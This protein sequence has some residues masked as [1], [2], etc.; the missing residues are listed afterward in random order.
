MG[1][2]DPP[3]REKGRAISKI[4]RNYGYLTEHYLVVLL[5]LSLIVL[6]LAG[7]GNAAIVGAMGAAL[8]L[9]GCM[10]GAVKVDLYILLPLLIFDVFS[11]AS[12][13]HAYGTFA[14]GFAPTQTVFTVLYLLIACLDDGERLSLR[15]MCVLWVGSVAALGIVQFALRAQAAYVGRL[16]GLLGN[17]NA[18]GIFLVVGW[19]AMRAWKNEG[20][21]RLELLEPIIL[22]ALAMTLSLGSFLSMA[23]GM[24]ASFL[25]DC[26]QIGLRQ[27]IC[28][29]RQTLAR[30]TVCVGIGM[31]LYIAGRKSGIP[32]LC[33]PLTL[34]LLMLALDWKSFSSF[35]QNRSR[36]A[37]TLSGSGIAVAGAAVLLRPS[38]AATFVERLEMMKSGLRYIL[39]NPFLGVGPYR[40]RVL[41]YND[42]G[43]YFNTWHIHNLFLHVGVELGL[44]A[45][46]ALIAVTIRHFCKRGEPAAKCGSAAFLLHCM[47]DTGFF[48]E[49]V[50]ALALLTVSRPREG[51]RRLGPALSRALF[52][53]LGAVFLYN[54]LR[55]WI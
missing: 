16:G 48:Y 19:F 54:L 20:R 47:M 55:L 9:A 32:W 10:Q 12:S 45:M 35:L 41:D 6:T 2:E 43:I 37:M 8:C 40:W 25:M 15:R 28:R 7:V 33:V 44:V 30:I 46:G 53:L 38:A 50:P 1:K 18:F 23:M 24:L 27:S 49:A 26:R 22:A 29:I 34:Y 52:G 5:F 4:K 51:G 36:V 11:M 13:W 21:D 42:G 31:L 3:R 14:E 39:T 17:P